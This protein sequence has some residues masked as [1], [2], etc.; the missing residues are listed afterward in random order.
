VWG[1]QASLDGDVAAASCGSETNAW[2]AC[3]N[4]VCPDATCGDALDACFDYAS[5]TE[6]A[7]HTESDAC[8][9]EW[10]AASTGVPQCADLITLMTLWCGP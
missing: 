8:A 9:A 3:A 1:C 4:E 2:Q 6:C 10:S 7:G 5:E